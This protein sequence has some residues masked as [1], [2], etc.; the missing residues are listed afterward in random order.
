MTENQAREVALRGALVSSVATSTSEDTDPPSP[1]LPKK[2][3]TSSWQRPSKTIL[4]IGDS[5]ISRASFRDLLTNICYD[6]QLED[7]T[8][9]QTSAVVSSG[10]SDI[11]S[12]TSRRYRLFGRAGKKL[13]VLDI[14]QFTNIRGLDDEIAHRTA[15]YQSILNSTGGSSWGHFYEKFT[16][17]ITETIDCIV[18]L[19]DGMKPDLSIETEYALSVLLN[20]FPSDFLHH[21]AFLYTNV[22]GPLHFSF[23]HKT[24]HPLFRKCQFWMMDNPMPG[25][26]MYMSYLNSND[27]S[28]MEHLE[29]IHSSV[30]GVYEKAQETMGHFFD[31]L[32]RRAPI[33]VEPIHELCGVSRIIDAYLDLLIANAYHHIDQGHA[34]G[35]RDIIRSQTKVRDANQCYTTQQTT[36]SFTRETSDAYN[37]VCLS[38][39]CH[40]NCHLEC[41]DAPSS[42][43]IG[44][45][46]LG[47]KCRS[48]GYLPSPLGGYT[49]HK[50]PHSSRHHERSR[51]K[52]VD[53]PSVQTTIHVDIEQ[54]HH[55]SNTAIDRLSRIVE[56]LESLVHDPSDTDVD[57]LEG[58]L[59][60]DLQ[61]F[62]SMFE[63]LALSPSFA[64]SLLQTIRVARRRYEEM[65]KEGCAAE[66]LRRARE[67]IAQ[68]EKRR[69]LVKGPVSIPEGLD[70]AILKHTTK[71][72]HS[73][74]VQSCDL[75]LP[76]T[77]LPRFLSIACVFSPCGL[78]LGACSLRAPH[79]E[80][81][82]Q[83]TMSNILPICTSLRVRMLGL[84][85]KANLDDYA[86]VLL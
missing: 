62:L 9:G 51:S 54:R 26:I 28:H 20:I 70:A 14:P 18:V 38:D 71:H 34:A 81:T 58:F 7:L 60:D 3:A 50:C 29:E 73:A 12:T 30:I 72:V 27:H 82:Y 78:M 5:A 67:V 42:P 43:Q 79:C 4:L 24:L 36:S 1:S 16:S 74:S 11:A 85:L 69:L 40:S 83:V 2:V 8:S 25:W 65:K 68:L 46:T 61:L 39:A 45:D 21:I 84:D 37:T 49:C 6:R 53:K 13:E 77:P 19:I 35:L 22:P 57:E 47:L 80:E 10:L 75:K 59:K 23:N 44:P 17:L 31:W 48:F 63:E 76:S 32:D 64:E 41:N 86:P 66:E 55:R 33:P 52:W 56:R 15:I